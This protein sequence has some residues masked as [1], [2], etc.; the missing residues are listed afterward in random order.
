MYWIVTDSAIDMPRHWI[1]QQ[2]NFRV[3]DLSY[4]M[5][6]VSYTSDGTDESIKA[7]YD[8]MRSG[9]MLKTSQVTPEMWENCFRELLQAG[10]DVLTIAFSSGL[11]GTCSAAFTAADEVR[12]DYPDRKLF[13][14]DS[15]QASAGEGLMVHY[16]LENRRNGMSIEENA[17]WVQQNVQNFLAWFT[18]NDLMHLHRGGRVS[19]A[20]AIV[21][22]LVHIKPIMHVDAEGKLAVFEKAAG[23]KRSIRIL[24][25]KIAADIVAP[26]K[27][28]IHISHGDCLEEAQMLANLIREALP[29]IDVRISYVGS[30]IGAHTGPGVIAIFCM[31]DTRTPKK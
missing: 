29:V 13:V 7:I 8:A 5:D 3:L 26:E 2:E 30:V 31:G 10:H 12:A 6:D 4:L 28:I 16:A 22:S 24:A 9:K 18:V 15:L 27:Q 23:R 19:A 21:G 20:S 14:I 1:D 11:S 25:E 17:A